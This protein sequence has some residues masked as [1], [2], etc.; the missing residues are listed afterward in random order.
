MSEQQ[1]PPT[2]MVLQVYKGKKVGADKGFKLLKNKADALKTKFR[3]I[4][5]RIHENKM[6]M[7]DESSVA[8]F[9]LTQAEYAAGNLKNK[10]LENQ[11]QA[12]IRVQT[13]T[14][15]VAGVKLP[16]FDAYETNIGNDDHYSL[17][18]GG[19]GRKIAA[20]RTK[21][22]N[23]LTSLVKL[24]SLQT[25][26][27]AMDEALKITNRRVN[28]LENVTIPRIA[29]IINY[30]NRELD[31]LEREDF[32]R[33][34]MVKKKKEHHAI[35]EAKHK[36]AVDP[37]AMDNMLEHDDIFADFE[38]ET[39]LEALDE[40]DYNLSSSSPAAAAGKESAFNF[41]TQQTAPPQAP[42]EDPGAS[43]VDFDSD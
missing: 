33:L 34:K 25:S 9:S 22:S 35:E 26:F 31:E 2:R 7:A 27:V 36:L 41:A 21:Y 12:S 39:A 6:G 3:D 23:Y 43:M 10:V 5:K 24:A 20:C 32:S 18:L 15:N 14:D 29:G 42:M 37:H 11:M 4:C 40:E 16:V 13:R 30:I 28:A 1:P 17:G 38:P 19:G 8:C